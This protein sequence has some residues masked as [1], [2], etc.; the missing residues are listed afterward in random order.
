[1]IV[2]TNMNISFLTFHPMFSNL[3][4]TKSF[5]EI[6]SKII[7]KWINLLSSCDEY[8]IKNVNNMEAR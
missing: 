2:N 7:T 6:V 3:K 4:T 5:D 1:M 8:T